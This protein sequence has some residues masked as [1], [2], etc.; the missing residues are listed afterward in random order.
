[1]SRKDKIIIGLLAVLGCIV[2]S[3]I[4]V[5]VYVSIIAYATYLCIRC[6]CTI[7]EWCKYMI[8]VFTNIART[9]KLSIERILNEE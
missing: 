2:V 1:M 4:L 3:P 7:K 9:A 8:E 5:L 6:K